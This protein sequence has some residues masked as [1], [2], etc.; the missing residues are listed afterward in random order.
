MHAWFEP[1]LADNVSRPCL[2]IGCS[3]APPALPGEPASGWSGLIRIV[4]HGNVVP[5]YEAAPQPI[6]A[7]IA[8]AV[9]HRGVRDV[10]VC[11]HSRC[12]ALRSLLLPAELAPSEA[13]RRWSAHAAS[14][15]ALL[16]RHYLHLSGEALWEVALQEHVLVQIEHLLTHPRLREAVDKAQVRLHAWLHDEDESRILAFEPGSGQFETL[17]IPQPQRL[18]ERGGLPRD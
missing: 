11:G 17:V 10:V 13:Q 8:H 15:R 12:Q 6:A 5:P 4:S 7:S 9:T 18:S 1:A 3:D 14:T 2:F 16:R